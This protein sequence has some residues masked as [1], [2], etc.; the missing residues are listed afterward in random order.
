MY[1]EAWSRSA[2]SAPESNRIVERY[3]E[4]GADEQEESDYLRGDLDAQRNRAAFDLLD[5][6]KDHQPAIDD[7]KRKEVD[8]RKVGGN[9]GHEE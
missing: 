1:Y 9:D 8:D 5:D 7:R 3:V 2:V 6:Q 4:E